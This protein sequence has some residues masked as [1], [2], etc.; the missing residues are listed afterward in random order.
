MSGL[1]NFYS[2]SV[3]KLRSSYLSKSHGTHQ[4]SFP[5]LFVC[6][7]SSFSLCLT[8]YS[9]FVLTYLSVMWCS[10][11]KIRLA[12][13]FRLVCFQQV[14]VMVMMHQPHQ[15]RDANHQLQVKMSSFF[16]HCKILLVKKQNIL[17]A[18]I[19]GSFPMSWLTDP[20]RN[21]SPKHEA[22][23][24]IYSLLCCSTHVLKEA[25][26]KC[27]FFMNHHPLSF[28]TAKHQKWKI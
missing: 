15:R 12:V 25:E 16:L 11:C 7:H 6:L 23:V 17:R 14:F 9:I 24:I 4:R 8:L 10:L 13:R 3:K 21:S 27:L 20:E 18:W 19:D 28:Y 1:S 26:Q 5:S 22:F 2:E